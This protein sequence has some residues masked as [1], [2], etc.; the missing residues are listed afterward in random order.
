[1]ERLAV[2]ERLVVLGHLGPFRRPVMA[3]L[4]VLQGE[5]PVSVVPEAGAVGVGDEP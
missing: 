2:L 3:G 1:L 4:G 5:G